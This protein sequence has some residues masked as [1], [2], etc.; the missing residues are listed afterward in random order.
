MYSKDLGNN[1]SSQGATE[2]FDNL[3][4]NNTLTALILSSNYIIYVIMSNRKL[5]NSID[6]IACGF[7]EDC[8]R[9]NKTLLA[10]N[11]RCMIDD[12]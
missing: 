10:F 7:I 2:I 8:L 3:K 6:D 12:Y 9:V 11:I 1:I 5:G 4:T